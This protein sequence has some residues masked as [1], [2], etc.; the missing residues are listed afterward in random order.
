MTA[1][2]SYQLASK[3]LHEKKS[4]QIRSILGEIE[5][6]A[7]MG[8][9]STHWVES[10]YDGVKTELLKLG[11][12]VKEMQNQKDGATVTISWSSYS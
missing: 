12:N 7:R 6:E 1:E 11:Y 10:L 8:K 5:K 4:Q 9:F 2:E 3:I